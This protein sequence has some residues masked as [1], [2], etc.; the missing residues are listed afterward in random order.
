MRVVVA[1]GLALAAAL[2]VTSAASAPADP[3]A[4]PA[5][6]E[7]VIRERLQAG[8]TAIALG[9]LALSLLLA[10]RRERLPAP[11]AAPGSPALPDSVREVDLYRQRYGVS[12]ARGTLEPS[13][14][15]GRR[16]SLRAGSGP[17]VSWQPPNAAFSVPA[18][19]DAG[20]QPLAALTAGGR[21]IA[22]LDP[23]TGRVVFHDADL[24][25]LHGLGRRG[26]A[27]L[28]W[29]LLL[30]TG[31]FAGLADRAL[32]GFLAHDAGLSPSQLRLSW[33]ITAGYF[34]VFEAILLGA[35]LAVASVV[36]RRV[37]GTQFRRRYQANLAAALESA[38]RDTS[39]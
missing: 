31:A 9:A 27:L 23:V 26:R 30:A 25:R 28:L 17:A 21:A 11:P 6:L 38:A 5:P 37:R 36:L 34:A 15:S 8:E 10:F 12:F 32:D 1:G 35:A 13:G 19:G 22:S 18:G 7:Q 33:L 29:P 24:S 16:L 4:S 14:R 39:V 2:A 20:A 3:T